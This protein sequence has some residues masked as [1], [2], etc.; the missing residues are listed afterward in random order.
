MTV[1][2]S[3]LDALERDGLALAARLMD[4]L[5]GSAVPVVSATD[6]AAAIVMAFGHGQAVVANRARGRRTCRV[7]GCCELSACEGGCSWAAADL[8]SRCP[9][10]Q[11]TA[12]PG[13]LES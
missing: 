3:S 5:C 11:P 1:R 8:C 4:E 13:Q 10:N 6:F 12:R 2:R 7:C 9:D